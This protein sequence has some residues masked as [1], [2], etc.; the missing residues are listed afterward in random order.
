M[1]YPYLAIWKE[2][3]CLSYRLMKH[4]PHIQLTSKWNCF[5]SQP[6]FF[7]YCVGSPFSWSIHVDI[8]SPLPALS[9]HD[10]ASTAQNPQGG[11][12]SCPPPCILCSHQAHLH[13]HLSIMTSTHF[14]VPPPSNSL[15]AK[16]KI[17]NHTQKSTWNYQKFII[18][19]IV[20]FI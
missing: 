4:L 13:L 14:L 8:A 11:Q 3:R 20:L 2:C 12:V 7:P 1:E 17:P 18:F 16:S 5:S 10:S 19:F 9:S 6:N 15:K